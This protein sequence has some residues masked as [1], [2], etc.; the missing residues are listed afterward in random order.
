MQL[1]LNHDAIYASLVA[2]FVR[3]LQS[4]MEWVHNQPEHDVPDTFRFRL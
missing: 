3:L 2:R 4:R 1:I